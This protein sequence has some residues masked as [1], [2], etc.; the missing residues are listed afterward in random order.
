M[1]K[2]VEVTAIGQLSARLVRDGKR[3][4]V[5]LFVRLPSGEP[6]LFKARRKP[7]RRVKIE[8]R[9]AARKKRRGKRK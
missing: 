2:V 3:E 7:K 1:K 6:G 5:E 8:K 4:Y 9:Q